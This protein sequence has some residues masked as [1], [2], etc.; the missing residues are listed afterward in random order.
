MK[1]SAEMLEGL[2][3]LVNGELLNPA[4]TCA[5]INPA[6]G[7]ILAGA[8][9]ADA[10]QLEQAVKAA[11]CAGLSGWAA[12]E[13]GRRKV[14]LAAAQAL[15]A[16]GAQLS[17][18]LCLEIG[19]PM[20]A[21]QLEV[22]MSAAF[23]KHRAAASLPVDVLYDDP[24][25][26]VEVVRTPI[27][28]VGA[29]LPWNAP[30]LIASEKIS[31]AFIVGNTVVLKPS[32]LAPLTVALMG[33]V[34]QRVLPPG[35]LNIVPGDDALG[36]ALVAH[37]DVRMISFTGSIRAGKSIMANAA[38]GL[39]RL[40]LEL[41]GNDAAIVLPDA[42]VERVASRIVQTAFY[43]SGQICATIKRLYVHERLFEPLLAAL[44]R[45]V[46]AIVLGDPFDAS[47]TMGPLSNRAQFDR[48]RQLVDAAQAAGGKLVSGVAPS[49]N[50]YY[51]APT[52]VTGLESGHALIAEEQ[53]GPVLPVIPYGRVEDAVA[54]ANG[55]PYGLGGSVWGS[56][57]DAACLIARGLDS[58]TVWVNRHGLVLPDI[59]FGGTKESGVGRSN[60]AAGID[61]YAE[62]KTISTARS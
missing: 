13:S 39:K 24:K 15:E 62:L 36:A 31:T 37:P 47:V 48:V 50:G 12:D 32:L 34:L 60:G 2:P 51:V 38:P 40:S 17:A 33:R 22:A 29:I 18:A 25:Q 11:R 23:M 45:A 55:T 52:L 10:D 58:G 56:D 6:S 59:P 16:H 9:V 8:P 41:G 27:G 19:I 42:N 61:Q 28:V 30:L 7:E 49:G 44:T 3:L 53:F 54:A 46:Q 21:A 20:K 43:R 4:Q 35:V 14:L 1:S 26:R 57:V 5:V